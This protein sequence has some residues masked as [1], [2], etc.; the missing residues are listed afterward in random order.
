[1]LKVLEKAFFSVLLPSPL[2]EMWVNIRCMH[3]KEKRP[4]LQGC[5]DSP[6]RGSNKF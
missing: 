6:T 1:M 2:L 3:K 5:Q 4:S